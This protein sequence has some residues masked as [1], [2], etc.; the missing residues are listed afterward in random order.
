MPV[1]VVLGVEAP[2]EVVLASGV[3]AVWEGGP[4]LKRGSLKRERNGWVTWCNC[5]L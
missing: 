3:K 2:G 1:V 4:E 5:G